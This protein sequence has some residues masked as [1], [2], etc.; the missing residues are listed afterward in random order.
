MQTDGRVLSEC[1]QKLLAQNPNNIEATYWLGQTYFDMDDNN[2]AKEV[3]EKGLAASNNAPLLLVGM[4]HYLLAEKKVNEARQNFETALSMSKDKKGK[5]NPDILNAIGRAHTDSKAGDYK[6]A[7]Q[8]LRTAS[9]LNP[10]NPDIFL[11]L[12]NAIRKA[13]PG[14]A[15][16][17]AY[18]AFRKATEINPNFPYAYVRIAKLFETQRNWELV[19]ENLNIS[20]CIGSQF[21]SCLL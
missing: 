5:D 8:V 3:Y 14:E 2:M 21:Q 6:Y 4:G 19:L 17:D 1:F 9:E 11:N 15:G 16:K 20:S 12:G 7:E 18:E 10:K 13:R